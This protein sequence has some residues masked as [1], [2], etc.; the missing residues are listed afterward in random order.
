MIMSD[1]F[2][3]SQEIIDRQS[4]E[5]NLRGID[6]EAEEPAEVYPGSSV[7]ALVEP[8]KLSIIG[9]ELVILGDLSSRDVLFIS[10]QPE[11]LL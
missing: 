3:H 1:L 4:L 9:D 8:D 7:V 6:L 11:E 2:E 5:L 10:E